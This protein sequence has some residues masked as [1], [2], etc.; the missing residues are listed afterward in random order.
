MISSGF[1]KVEI[2]GKYTTQWIEVT[3]TA[4]NYF[5]KKDKSSFFSF[6]SGRSQ[7]GSVD[8]DY[9]SH[10]VTTSDFLFSI[11][12]DDKA[13]LKLMTDTVEDKNDWM[14]I[15]E[16]VINEEEI[17]SRRL[18]GGGGALLFDLPSPSSSPPLPFTSEGGLAPMTPPSSRQ[19]YK[20]YLKEYLNMSDSKDGP[21]KQAW[22]ILSMEALTYYSSSASAS[23]T[24]GRIGS[25]AISESSGVHTDDD[26]NLI[27]NTFIF[28]V[29]NNSDGNSEGGEQTIYLAATSEESRLRWMNTIHSVKKMNLC[30]AEGDLNTMW[31]VGQ[32]SSHI[33]E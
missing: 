32:H 3:S 27:D 15:I 19:T 4:F 14:R 25:L 29:T 7:N 6:S 30:R 21:W 2:D 24:V 11:V 10:V 13:A 17:D 31:Q 28:R 18:S 26:D 9:H 23:R 8:L 12:R 33:I 1:L 22:F 5:D 16:D 20:S